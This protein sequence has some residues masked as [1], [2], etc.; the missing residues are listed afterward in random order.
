M[1]H[2]SWYW[3]SKY[4]FSWK[5]NNILRRKKKESLFLTWVYPTIISVTG[6]IMSTYVIFSFSAYTEFS[7]SLHYIAETLKQLNDRATQH[8]SELRNHNERIYKN[9]T[10]VDFLKVKE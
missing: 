8:E 5:R 3:I 2:K 9:S 7:K 10:A 4:F 1:S 6:V